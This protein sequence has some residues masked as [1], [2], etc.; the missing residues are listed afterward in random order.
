MASQNTG[1]RSAFTLIELL[2]VI[3]IIALLISLLLPALSRARAQ[4]VLVQCASNLRQLGIACQMYGT[5][6]KG[7]VLRDSDGSNRW[8]TALMPPGTTAG[9]TDPV[10]TTGDGALF[11]CPAQTTTDPST[12][13]W[14]YGGGYGINHDLAQWGLPA[15]PSIQRWAASSRKVSTAAK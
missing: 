12:S 2:V 10:L 3:G 13:P 4:A 8:P 15:R 6:N 14:E 7:I 11:N 1:R 5:A 9:S